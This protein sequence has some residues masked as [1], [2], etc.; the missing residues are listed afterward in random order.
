MKTSD[1]DNYMKQNYVGAKSVAESKARRGSIL[2]QKDSDDTELDNYLK[3]TTERLE[4][5]K[6]FEMML[7]KIEEECAKREDDISNEEEFDTTGLSLDSNNSFE[8]YI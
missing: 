8:R 6:N 7:L 2:R 5:G 3:K 1:A 4:K